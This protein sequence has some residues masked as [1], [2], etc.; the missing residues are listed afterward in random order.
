ML[1]F[2]LATVQAKALHKGQ[3]HLALTGLYSG[4]NLYIENGNFCKDSADNFWCT[5][6]VTVNGK[7]VQVERSSAYEIYLDSLGFKKGDSIS[8]VIYH[9]ACCKPKLL[10]DW[11]ATGVGCEFNSLTIDS[12]G[13][14]NWKTRKE[15]G[16]LFFVVQ[17]YRWN[18]WIKVAEVEGKGGLGENEYSLKV[19]LHSGDN[20]FRIMHTNSSNLPRYS[21]D[22]M[23]APRDKNKGKIS[24]KSFRI[25]KQL[26][27]TAESDYQIFDAYGNLVTK[28]RGISVDC[29]K[30]PRGM[31]YVCFDNE[32]TEFIKY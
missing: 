9:K 20:K 3:E 24:L 13:M 11:P 27:F 28:G 32:I 14:L 18:K 23:Y 16:K 29:S 21:K 26:E 8:I 1:L 10:Y 4:K 31:Y 22:I 30:M 2:L 19:S 17:N 5:T 25:Q 7:E 6:A 12:T 15:G